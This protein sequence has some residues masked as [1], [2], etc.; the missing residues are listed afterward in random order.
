[1]R[2]LLSCCSSSLRKL[3]WKMSQPVLAESLV[4]FVNTFTVDGECPAQDC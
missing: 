2:A 3:I 4:V 1:M